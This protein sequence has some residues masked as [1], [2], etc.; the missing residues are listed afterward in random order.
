AAAAIPALVSLIRPSRAASRRAV[1]FQPAFLFPRA[2]GRGITR[3]VHISTNSP[4]NY[5]GWQT[6][7]GSPGILVSTKKRKSAKGTATDGRYRLGRARATRAGLRAGLRR[8]DGPAGDPR[9]AGHRGD[10]DAGRA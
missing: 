8:G 6:K 4:V 2:P 3:P 9:A 7:S 5:C 10:P 1:R